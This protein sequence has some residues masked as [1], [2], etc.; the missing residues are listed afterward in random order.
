MIVLA[1]ISEDG[2]AS[3]YHAKMVDGA[4]IKADTWYKLE[5]GDFVEVDDD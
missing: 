2:N 3:R 1:E 5:N 4:E